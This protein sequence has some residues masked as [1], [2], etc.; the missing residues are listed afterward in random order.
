[1]FERNKS[2]IPTAVYFCKYIF[3]YTK[4]YTLYFYKTIPMPGNLV[5]LNFAVITVV[6]MRGTLGWK[7]ESYQE[8]LNGVL[9]GETF[10]LGPLPS[11]S[12]IQSSKEVP[13]L[14]NT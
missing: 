14:S 4:L 13:L 2:S 9:R 10:L 8:D 5:L 7:N 6:E 1:M 3:Q 11:L 12:R